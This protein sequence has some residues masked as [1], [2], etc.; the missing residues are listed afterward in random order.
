MNPKIDSLTKKLH[1]KN[2]RSKCCI[3]MLRHDFMEHNIDVNE[4]SLGYAEISYNPQLVDK[5]IIAEILQLSGLSLIASREEKI[6]DEVKQAV[7][8]LI[9]EMNNIDSI[10]KKSEYIVE[11]LGLN[12]RYLSKIFS[13]NEGITLERYIILHKIER[14]KSM[15]D[16]EEYTLSEIAYMMDYSSVQYLATQ[17]KKETGY[18]V[19]DYKLLDQK[20][21]NLLSGFY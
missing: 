20:E 14:I 11:K 12:F 9:H 15:V 4:I 3:R 1:I 19:S 2:M 8:E 6:V 21:K 16:E 10:T 18:S 5:N 7:H 13:A 17:F